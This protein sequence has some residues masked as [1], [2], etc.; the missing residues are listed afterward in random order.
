M[1]LKPHYYHTIITT[2]SPQNNTNLKEI[3]INISDN[4]PY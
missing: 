2:S 3:Y 4:I 1:N